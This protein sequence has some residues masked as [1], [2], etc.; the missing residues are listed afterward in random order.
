MKN[1]RLPR[2]TFLKG[3][4]TTM[5][6]PFLEAM[7]PLSSIA[8]AAE[9]SGKAPQRLAFVYVPNGVNMADWTPAELGKEFKLP[10]ILEPLSPV[11]DDLLVISGLGHVNGTAGPDGAGDHARASATFLTG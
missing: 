7:S 1:W 6:L 9:G 4:G 3:L 8:A 11:K 10:S 5:A 2:R